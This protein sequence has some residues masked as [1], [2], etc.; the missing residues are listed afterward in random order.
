MKSAFFFPIFWFSIMVFGQNEPIIIPLWKNGAPGFEHLK[1]QPEKAQDWWVKNI[2]NPSITM[3]KP[4]DSHAIGT[5]VL[6][7]PGGGHRELV[8]DAEGKD[9][10]LYLNQF[11]ITAFV[12]KY[13]LAREEGSPY[14]LNVHAKQDAHRA[15]RT[16]RANAGKWHI[17][18]GK[19]G[20]LGFSA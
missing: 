5:A 20:M 12:L 9:A 14:D 1:A 16:I 18:P 15:L 2:H 7:C 6:I 17:N 19:L 10:A 4:A 13:R 11:G 3:F 8:F